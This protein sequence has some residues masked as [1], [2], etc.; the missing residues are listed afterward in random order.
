MGLQRR[1][2]KS[3]PRN[4]LKPEQKEAEVIEVIEVIAVIYCSHSSQYIT[5]L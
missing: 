4:N 3:H 5:A 1:G 2:A